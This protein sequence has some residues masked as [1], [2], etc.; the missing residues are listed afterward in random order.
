[1]AVEMRGEYLGNLK[2]RSTHGPSGA[3][4]DTEAPVDNGG[5]GGGFSPTDL[6]ATA[7]GAC[8][9]TVMGIVAKRDAIPLEGATFRVEKHMN[10]DPR[11]IARLPIAFRLPAGLGADA[12]KKLEAAAM[13]CPAK[14]SLLAEIEVHVTFEYPD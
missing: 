9:L 10:A 6:V 11:R 5:T 8:M 7:V 2:V 4:V 13:A 12:R 3:T 1:M 14:R